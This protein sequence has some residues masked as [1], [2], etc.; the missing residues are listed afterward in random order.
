MAV[1][2]KE[3]VEVPR[4][5]TPARPA[6]RRT[7]GIAA[8]LVAAVAVA[9]L[10]TVGI[11]VATGEEAAPAATTATAP[12]LRSEQRVLA[13]LA[14]LG[15]IPA[16]AVDWQTLR[17]EQLIA[18][19]LIPAQTLEPAG[20]PAPVPVPEP[21]FSESEELLIRLATTGQIPMQSV[22]WREVELK[23]LVNQ[24]LIPRATLND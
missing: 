21:L 8:W 22:D 18:Q 10:V 1:I 19:R 12:D 3:R 20:T 24:G 11:V 9:A 2:E 4:Y 23:R 17:T 14:A 5:R 13:D 7:M 6:R 15:Y 16:Q